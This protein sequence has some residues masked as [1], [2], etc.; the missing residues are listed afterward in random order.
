MKQDET[1]CP[2]C[3]NDATPLLAVQRPPSLFLR[4]GEP[5]HPDALPSCPHCGGLICRKDFDES[6]IGI[7]SDLTPPDP[8]REVDAV[9]QTAVRS[10]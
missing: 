6:R 2:D 8:W 7:F 9:L 5:R 3:G 10:E 1:E 4:S